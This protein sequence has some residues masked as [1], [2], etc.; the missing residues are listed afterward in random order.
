MSS[1]NIDL[2]YIIYILVEVHTLKTHLIL[3]NI[4]FNV[5]KIEI[6]IYILLNKQYPQTSLADEKSPQDYRSDNK[7]V[8]TEIHRHVCVFVLS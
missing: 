1:T 5:V 8:F 4:H 2:A 6:N 7:S 3:S